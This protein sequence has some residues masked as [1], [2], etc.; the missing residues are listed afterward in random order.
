MELS[1]KLYSKIT[2]LCEADDEYCEKEQYEKAIKKYKSALKLIPEPKYDWEASTWVYVAIG[3]SFYMLDQYTDAL[4]NF[5]ESL[6]CPD[7]N[8]NPFILLRLGECYYELGNF[9]QAKEY[10]LR[11]FMWEGE[12]IFDGEDEKYFALIKDMVNQ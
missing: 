6:K 3:D 4:N 12:D 2:S 1:D 5:L 11:A 9:E 10:L 7:G 8:T